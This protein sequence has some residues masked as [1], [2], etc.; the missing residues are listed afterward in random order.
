[1]SKP[2]FNAVH[3]RELAQVIT[4]PTPSGSNARQA[5]DPYAT[6]LTGTA[7]ALD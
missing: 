7:W 3:A 6:A 5:Q 4:P 1:M 2:R